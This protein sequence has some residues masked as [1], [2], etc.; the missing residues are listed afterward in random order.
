MQS[1]IPENFC[2]Q[3]EKKICI[4]CTVR[5]STEVNEIFAWVRINTC[6]ESKR[7]S[8]K[9][10]HYWSA[11]WLCS[12]I[13]CHFDWK[14][15]PILVGF[16]Y[17]CPLTDG[18]FTVTTHY[19]LSYG[20][21][22]CKKK[23]QKLFNWILG[24]ILVDSKDAVMP[25]LHFLLLSAKNLVVVQDPQYT[26]KFVCARD[27]SFHTVRTSG[28]FFFPSNTQ[29]KSA[30]AWAQ[31]LFIYKHAEPLISEQLYHHKLTCKCSSRISTL[32]HVCWVLQ[33]GAATNCYSKFEGLWV[34]FYC[35]RK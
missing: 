15:Y 24:Q 6:N 18:Q 2:L 3:E 14:S 33:N 19:C 21:C 11:C 9:Q 23:E 16:G 35:N 7:F 17:L 20:E 4:P 13:F 30:I 28:N 1:A 12:C 5:I 31:A 8:E 25:S 32:W 22:L 27:P 10:A 29:A 34:I 26:C